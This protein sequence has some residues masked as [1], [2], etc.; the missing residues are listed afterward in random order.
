MRDKT[1][2]LET[3]WEV[4]N[5]VGGIYTVIRS[6]V[7]AIVEK[8]GENY[9]LIGPYVHKNVAAEFEPVDDYSDA[10]GKAVLKMRE[11]G[12]EIHYGRWQVTGTPRVVLVNPYSVFHSLDKIK[13]FLWEHHSISSSHGD[14]LLDQV[15]AFGYL[16]NKFISELSQGNKTTDIIS[17]FHEWMAGT[18]IPELRR[19]K[20][21]NVKI[22]FTTHATLLGRY[23]AMNNGSFYDHLP[24]MDWA[25]EAKNFNIEAQAQIERA[26]A[27]GAHVFTTVSD[28]TSKEC[29][30]FLGRAPE[31]ILPNGL[32]IERFVALHEFQNLHKIYKDKISEFVMGHFFQSYSWDLDNTLYFFTS[33]RF[34]YT[35]KGFDVTLEALARLNWKM[36]EN[37]INTNVVMFFITKQPY[38]SINPTA[39]ETRAILEEIRETCDSI[40]KK[41]GE[42]LFYNAASNF[43]NKLPNLSEFVDDY[44]KLRL[45]RTLQTW[46]NSNLPLVVTHNLVN[47]A[48]DPILNYLRAANLVNHRH[49]PVKIVYHPD[50]IT[51]SNPLFGMDYSQFVRGCHLGVFPSYYEPW[52]YTPLECIASGVPTVTSDL[53]GFGDYVVANMPNHEETGIYVTNRKTKDYFA[54]AEQLSNQLLAFVKMNRRQRIDQRNKTERA[55]VGFDWS[56]LTKYYTVAYE[57]AILAE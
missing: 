41:V 30:Q 39:L 47:D 14:G 55:S 27:H 10:F 57:K 7:P 53:S 44:W 19:E 16:V 31:V 18:S 28:V 11:A 23:L 46:R 40:T 43:D 33:G 37:N 45:R 21:K 13:F 34:E 29:V 9:C 32:N 20:L 56:E 50:F 15:V 3:A 52:G 48:Q 38:Y 4:C 8:W 51:S 49:D 1:F 42:K 5:Q 36:K 17:H 6:K 2:L 12:F 35:N 26:A 22:V 24:F 54:S 25:K